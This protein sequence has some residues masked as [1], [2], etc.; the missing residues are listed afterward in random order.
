MIYCTQVTIKYAFVSLRNPLNILDDA[1]DVVDMP[2]Y[3][4]ML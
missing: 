4:Y 3:R 2:Y 1:V